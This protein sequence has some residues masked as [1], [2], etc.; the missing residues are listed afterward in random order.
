MLYTSD[1]PKLQQD[2][3]TL[4]GDNTAMLGLLEQNIEE[5][6]NNYKVQIHVLTAGKGP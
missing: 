5:I 2:I 1:I 6:M 4:F 3:I